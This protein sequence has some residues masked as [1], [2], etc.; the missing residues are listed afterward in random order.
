MNLT[1]GRGFLGGRWE[2]ESGRELTMITRPIGPV[3][4]DIDVAAVETANHRLVFQ[5]QLT[6]FLKHQKLTCLENMSPNMET[7]MG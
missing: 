5:R 3:V 6:W 1:H 4:I 2:N 7:S